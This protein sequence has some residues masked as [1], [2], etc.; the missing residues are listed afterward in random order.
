MEQKIKSYTIGE[1]LDI[2]IKDYATPMLCNST[3]EN[4]TYARKR[5]LK[6]YPDIESIP[7][8]QLTPL[9]FQ[10]MLNAL[11]TFCSK[12]SLAQIKVVYCES[13]QEGVRNNICFR[14]PIREV[15]IPKRA[16]KKKVT[17][18]TLQEQK[19]F[20]SVLIHFGTMERYVVQTFLL[21]GM[22][23]GE[24]IDLEWEDWNQQLAILRV[25]KSKTENGIRNIPLLPQVTEI[26]EA[27]KS[28]K[29]SI[30]YIFHHNGQKLTGGYLRYIC[31][32]ASK[33]AQ[34]KYI[35]PHML[36]HTFASRLFEAGADP[37][38]IAEILGHS[39]PAFT[40][41]TY[42]TVSEE[43]LAEQIKKLN[44]TL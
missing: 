1:W 21:T 13:Y 33:M 12:S 5:L 16:A 39:D 41:A 43:H 42:V 11:S 30:P 18:M 24:L 37:K 20:L 44:P 23:R 8:D 35:S 9:D 38:S 2:W 40:L 7:L 25:R 4:Y 36:R 15:Q 3:I 17:G 26:L 27:L 22:R 14:N 32:K 28:Q 29:A 31:E 10:R 34:I 19:A 6:Y